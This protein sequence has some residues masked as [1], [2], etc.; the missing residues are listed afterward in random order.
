MSG[1]TAIFG[2]AH[3]DLFDALGVAPLN[4][5]STTA[6]AVPPGATIWFGTRAMAAMHIDVVLGNF[7]LQGSARIVATSTKIVCSTFAAD[8]INNPPTSSWQ[9]TIIAKAKQ[10]AAN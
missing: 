7:P 4:D 2:E 6:F 1:A 10:K 5:A 3:A 9:L 8:P